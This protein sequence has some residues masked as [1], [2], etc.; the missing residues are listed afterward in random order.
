M[1]VKVMTA[2]EIVEFPMLKKVTCEMG[3]KPGK[4]GSSWDL[5]QSFIILDGCGKILKDVSYMHPEKSEEFHFR[6]DNAGKDEE[7]K[8][9]DEKISINFL[10]L[11]EHYHR[12]VVIMNIYEA[13]YKRQDLSMIKEMYL[14]FWDSK[15]E[16]IQ[17]EVPIKINK[18]EY[19]DKTGMIVGEFYKEGGRWKF[20][21]I[22]KAVSR[23]EAISDMKSMIA[24]KYIN[25]INSEKTWDEFLKEVC[26][27]RSFL[28]RLL[29]F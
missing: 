10:K 12:I 9:S 21:A 1:A 19:L 6:G 16:D 25:Q 4:S 27:E 7:G 3:W 8:F 18:K 22:E 24:K 20:Q 17:V 29:N 15:I 28:R 11:P 23:V 5:D 13:I 26:P 14:K 2:N